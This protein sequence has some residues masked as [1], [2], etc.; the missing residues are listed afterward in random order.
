MTATPNDASAATTTAS[1]QPRS[2]SNWWVLG[3]ATI[4]LAAAIGFALTRSD[5]PASVGPS[6]A[7][8]ASPALGAGDLEARV[9]ANP[10]DVDAWVQL[11]QLK[12]DAQD[13]PGAV[14]A[15]T[16]A[17]ELSPA[18]AG[19]WSALGEAQVMASPRGGPALPD[20]ALAAFRRATAIDADDPRSR[21]FLAVK[22]DIDGDHEGAI[23]DWLTLLGDTPQGAP[24]E[25]DLRRTIEQV[26]ARHNI[27]VAPRIAAVRQPALAPDQLPVA[28]QAIPGP[29]RQQ[30]QEAAALP[31]G[32]Q[33]MAV[34]S[35]LESLETKLRTNPAQ[36]DRWI[37]LMRSRMTLG[38]SVK[39]G[40]ALQAAI[41]ANP[42]DADRLRAQARL[43]GVPGA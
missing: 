41:R 39:A 37:M 30:M 16:K 2:R 29:T 19:F 14:A 11:G 20:S 24:W 8:P 18:V 27:A 6:A 28:A 23:A 34:A 36:P 40:E 21:Y 42:G 22:K 13:Y 12:F 9:A 5:D 3:G 25:D 10:D 17:T 7:A 38:E 43:L 32:Q 26:G 35:M 31:K 4:A 1:V 15:Y 33:D